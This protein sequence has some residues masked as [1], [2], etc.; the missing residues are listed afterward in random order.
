MCKKMIS[1]VLAAATA[2]SLSASVFAAETTDPS[3]KAME[4]GTL[5]STPTI[6]IT[7]PTVA[8]VVLNP[9]KMKVKV[10]ATAGKDPTVADDTTATAKDDTVM[11]PELT[12]ANKGNSEVQISV[13]GSVSLWTTVDA[14]G[15]ALVDKDGNPTKS[16]ATG[17]KAPWD[18]TAPSG[19]KNEDGT[20]ILG[21]AIT[22]GLTP[23]IS[24]AT[25]AIKQPTWDAKGEK[26][27]AG[28][29]KNSVLLYV[30]A[31][32][33]DAT[34][35]TFTYADTFSTTNTSQMLLTAKDT[36]KALVTIAAKTGTAN[37][38][39][40]GDVATAPTI[41]WDK[42]AKTDGFDL[43]LVFDASPVAPLPP[44]PETT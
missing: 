13:T 24:L 1:A 26:I 23:K 33:P 40:R 44:K 2:L 18:A 30:E 16:N 35:K 10:T 41:G 39:I 5:V 38:Q 6:N 34:G 31:G 7:W 4:V 29:T 11:G 37:L 43:H 42:V 8:A 27:V 20:P 22:S 21:K 19:Q 25:T 36:T 17:D 12:F 14:K 3:H 9:Y 15:N 32:T 28:D